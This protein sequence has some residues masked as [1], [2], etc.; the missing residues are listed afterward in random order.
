MEKLLKTDVF[1]WFFFQWRGVGVVFAGPRVVLHQ[2]HVA[3]APTHDLG[4]Q[5]VG[6]G[7]ADASVIHRHNKRLTNLHTHTHTIYKYKKLRY[8][9]RPSLRLPFSASALF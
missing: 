2:L 5:D 7:A 8:T 4:H 6:S 3:A 9:H 1:L